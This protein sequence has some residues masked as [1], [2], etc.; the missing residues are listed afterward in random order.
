MDLGIGLG[1]GGVQVGEIC[2]VVDSAF[3]CPH[4]LHV[5]SAS[6][7]LRRDKALLRLSAFTPYSR[8]HATAQ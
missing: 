1:P 4:P 8:Q 2:I 7:T 3:P 5:T 6:L